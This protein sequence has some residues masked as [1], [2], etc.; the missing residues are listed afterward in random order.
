LF[1]LTSALQAGADLIYPDDW[2]T[3]MDR[4][5]YAQQ[6]AN[7]GMYVNCEGDQILSICDIVA[8]CISDPNSPAYA[9]VANLITDI[10]GDT[11]NN[12]VPLPSENNDLD[13]VWGASFGA[14]ELVLDTWGEVQ[15]I[16][17]A[18]TEFAEAVGLFKA[19][20]GPLSPLQT[21]WIEALIDAG[22][23]AVDAYL[24]AQSTQDSWACELFNCIV[25]AGTPYQIT[26]DC[27]DTA[28]AALNLPPPFDQFGIGQVLGFASDYTTIKSFWQRLSDDQCNN[29]WTGLC[30]TCGTI[31]SITDWSDPRIVSFS[32]P[33]TIF[34]SGDVALEWFNNGI[35]PL[36]ITFDAP[37]CFGDFDFEL[38]RGAASSVPSVL[39]FSVSG[40]FVSSSAGGFGNGDITGSLSN[41]IGNTLTIDVQTPAQYLGVVRLSFGNDPTNRLDIAPLV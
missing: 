33:V 28:F 21:A 12:V 13:C 20:F 40:T 15:A 5:S 7:T 26:N 16:I 35:A 37:Y 22:P 31:D 1:R 39:R 8:D 23:A 25:D 30:A 11:I 3:L 2:Q 27:I 32:Q 34:G 9:A 41:A 29:D 14:Y 10:T 38:L 17:D 19:L 6:L 24:N 4:W 18:A 36:T